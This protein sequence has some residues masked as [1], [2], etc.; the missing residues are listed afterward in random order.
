MKPSDPDSLVMLAVKM[1][2]A[3]QAGIEAVA[4]K[5]AQSNSAVIRASLRIGLRAMAVKPE[6][7]RQIEAGTMD[8]GTMADFVAQFAQLCGFHVTPQPE[9]EWSRAQA[10][11]AGEHLDR[12][13]GGAAV[14]GGLP[15]ASPTAG[16]QDL[17]KLL[18]SEQGQ[19]LLREAIAATLASQGEASSRTPAA[20]ADA[21][22]EIVQ[23]A[24]AKS[25]KRKASA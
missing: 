14:A 18:S 24:R 11:A 1:H 25:P 10:K 5:S 8:G 9:E 15:E 21:G 22:P 7:V 6:L 2:P 20:G 19:A 23:P 3:L 13:S 16:P 12:L 4:K 17:A